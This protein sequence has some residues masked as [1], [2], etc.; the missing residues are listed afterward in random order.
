MAVICS[1]CNTF[2][3]PST[4]ILYRHYQARSFQRPRLS[5]KCLFNPCNRL[6]KNYRTWQNHL[7]AH[8]KE[9]TT[10][11][12]DDDDY[13]DDGG[14][15]RDIGNEYNV[16]DKDA[17]TL[18]DYCAKWILNMSETRKLTRSAS[19]GIVQDV[20]EL[21]AK[22]ACKLKSQIVACLERTNAPLESI[23][24]LNEIFSPSNSIVS[25]FAGLDTFHS[26]MAYFKSHFDFIVCLRAIYVLTF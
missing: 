4:K 24:R 15:E 8:T 19:V 9:S 20:N 23:A 14:G 21:V 16:S 7:L 12:E 10:R 17:G 2:S 22:V 18:T 3:A 6:F 26:Q 11:R 1:I 13:D 5:I 25:P